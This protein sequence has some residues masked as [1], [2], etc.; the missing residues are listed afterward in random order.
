MRLVVKARDVC[1][2]QILFFATQCVLPL[3][4]LALALRHRCLENL[5][6]NDSDVYTGICL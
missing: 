6:Q 4:E 2:V 3:L 1:R 5:R